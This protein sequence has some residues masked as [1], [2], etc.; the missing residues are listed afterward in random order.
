[1]MGLMM[2][3]MREAMRKI[4]LIAAGAAVLLFAGRFMMNWLTP[5]PVPEGPMIGVPEDGGTTNYSDPNAPKELQSDEL[6]SFRAK[7]LL[8]GECG[9][10]VNGQFVPDEKNAKRPEGQYLLTLE[11][12]ENGK[13]AYT[14]QCRDPY[15]E[16]YSV[17]L[18]FTVDGKT[19]AQL[20]EVIAAHQLV[21]INGFSMWN[22][23]LGTYVDVTAQYA[24][25]ETLSIYGEGGYSASPPGE[26]WQP[27]WFIDFFCAVAEE[28]G[29]DFV[30]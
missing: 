4:F 29:Y 27:Q 20:Q 7:F 11:K 6:V 15:E 28:N 18:S 8:E 3:E 12:L 13:A 14:A 17:D 10:I 23:A 25:G 1:M 26:Y 2:P 9:E 5:E 22:S 21:K 16:G 19:L 24:N 30:Q